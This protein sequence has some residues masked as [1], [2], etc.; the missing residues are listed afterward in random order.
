M[1]T[2]SAEING[3]LKTRVKAMNSTFALAMIVNLYGEVLSGDTIIT[4]CGKV[5]GRG[6]DKRTKT[7]QT[8][9]TVED[10]RSMIEN[11]Y[12]PTYKQEKEPSIHD[13]AYKDYPYYSQDPLGSVG[14]NKHEDKRNSFI[15]GFNACKEYYNIK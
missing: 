13:L 6:E 7:K 11:M 9:A 8:S 15:N 2:Y 5:G 12:S 1:K 14:R 3:V 10:V 4:V